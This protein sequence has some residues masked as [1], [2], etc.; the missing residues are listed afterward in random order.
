MREVLRQF[1]AIWQGAKPIQ[2]VSLLTVV[3]VLGSA[4]GFTVIHSSGGKYT[5]LFTRLSSSEEKEVRKYLESISI[6]Y[7]EKKGSLWVAANQAEALREEFNALGIPKKEQ[8]KGFELFDSNTWIK[9]EK[10]LQVL[11]MRALK[12]QLERDLAGF[13]NIKSA[14]VILD[15]APSR[16]FGG[17][18][19]KTKASAILTL[20]PK[21]RLNT[22]QLSAITFHLTGAVR[23]LEPNMI[24]ISDTTGRLYQAIES[25]GVDNA[26][27]EQER[28][29]DEVCALLEKMI[30]EEHFHCLI[31]GEGVEIFVD[32]A[33]WRANMEGEIERCVQAV[34]SFTPRVHTMAFKQTWT[35]KEKSVGFTS[36]LFFAA[37]VIAAIAIT[38]PFVRK[39]KPE[40]RLLK[41]APKVDMRRL[42]ESL[43]EEDPEI[44]AWTLSYLEPR[45]AEEMIA[46][47]PEKYQEAVL[48]HLSEME[49]GGL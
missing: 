43:K 35:K 7:K 25:E 17:Q 31:K 22:S 26:I 19:Y 37:M 9:G 20:M 5:Q 1:Y 36:S 34:A 40:Y 4:L 12:G 3:I 16:K 10:E 27:I 42:A 45:R 29:K 6:P 48:H 39:R 33:V 28:L 38:F 13:E 2:K 23:G 18:Q 32:Q 46:S 8:G 49:K 15:L 21:A 14:R 30:G 41:M 44:V 11:E 24:A 47:F